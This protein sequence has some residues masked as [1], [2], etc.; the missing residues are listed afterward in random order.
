MGDDFYRS[1]QREYT[2]C[3]N[4]LLSARILGRSFAVRL[5]MEQILHFDFK[6]PSKVGLYLLVASSAR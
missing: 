5:T 4:R 3:F 1:Y 2:K 6:G